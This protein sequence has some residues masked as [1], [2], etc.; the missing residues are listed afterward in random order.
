[1]ALLAPFT[2]AEKQSHNSHKFGFTLSTTNYGHWKTMIQSFLVTNKLFPYVDGTITCPDPFITVPSTDKDQPLASQQNPNHATWVSNDAHVRMLLLSTISE[3]AFQHV[4][5]DTSRELWIALERAFA[6][7]TISREYTLK[8]QLLR[9]KME[10]DETSSAYLL[11]ARQYADALANLGEPFK[12]NT[13][14][15]WLLLV[16]VMSMMDSNHRLWVDNFSLPF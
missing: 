1:M 14:L 11:R 16:F 8:S 3:S 6:P 2:T 13:L 9:L 7:H 4:Q 15:Y 12:E 10:P 5:G